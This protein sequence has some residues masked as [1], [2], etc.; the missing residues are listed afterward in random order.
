MMNMGK[1]EEV[2]GNVISQKTLDDECMSLEES[3]KRIIEKIHNHF[4]TNEMSNMKDN[5]GNKTW[6]SRY[7]GR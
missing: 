4:V 5:S 2:S 6:T 1:K 3:K 7:V